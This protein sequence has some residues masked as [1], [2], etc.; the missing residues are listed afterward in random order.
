MP[1]NFQNP[2]SRLTTGNRY[3]QMLM[4]QGNVNN[5]T[6]TGGLAHAL[7]QG[8]AGYM[9][10]DERRKEEEYRSA[11][12]AAMKSVLAGGGA[13][14]GGGKFK[15]SGQAPG[16]NPSLG[17]V[18]L[19]PGIAANGPP[20]TAPQYS[21][22]TPD[23]TPSQGALTAAE[24]AQVQ[25]LSAEA[26]AM[27]N[28]GNPQ[29]ADPLA[30]S[31]DE[32]VNQRIAALSTDVALNPPDASGATN[33]PQT[34]PAPFSVG[35]Q[36]AMAAAPQGGGGLNL[37][38]QTA[39]LVQALMAGGNIEGAMQVVY[40]EQARMQ[41]LKDKKE[42]F[43]W[44]QEN[45][46]REP[47]VQFEV[48][49]NPY[50][51]GGTA[52]RNTKTGQLSGY[53]GP[54]VD[55]K[56]ETAK[57]ANDVLRYM[58]DGS[59]VFS[60]DTVG[61]KRPAANFDEEEKLRKAFTAESKDF[62]KVRDAWSRIHASAQDPSA[63]GDLALIFNYM[64]VL[65]PGSTVREGEFATAQNSAGIPARIV[66]KYNQIV[67][68]ERLDAA[69]RADFV[70]RG[71][72][73]YQTQANQYQGLE[74]RYRRLAEGYGFNPSNVVYPMGGDTPTYGGIPDVASKDVYKQMISDGTLKAGDSY[75][76]DGEIYI[77]GDD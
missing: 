32:E 64:K 66:A 45:T 21:L 6:T 57:D 3:A 19:S 71:Y 9:M 75:R 49:E 28:N 42:L 61:G 77:V 17:Q 26:D 54:V 30:M 1:I 59:P 18:P 60:E 67:R 27:W 74:D 48:V 70:D 38:P 2:G 10:G 76:R 68:G 73:L 5:G 50:G 36:D 44:E 34:G 53:Q 22:G 12:T 24:Q 35:I 23:G 14:A 43:K 8:L 47:P 39:Q 15:F 72:R 4:R 37:P 62:V 33:M 41:A 52:Q 63:A 20:P 7:R 46:Y 55:P 40:G 25:K 16:A 13:P 31:P 58:D 69:Q 29:I 56:R 11:M 51:R 65:D